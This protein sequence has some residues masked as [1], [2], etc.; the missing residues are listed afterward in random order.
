M[1]KL[2]VSVLMGKKHRSYE[3]NDF[4]QYIKFFAVLGAGPKEKRSLYIPF[5]NVMRF[6][7]AGKRAREA[8]YMV[9]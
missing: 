8:H 3:H 7:C 1:A 5:K 4:D 6:W 2:Q 9:R